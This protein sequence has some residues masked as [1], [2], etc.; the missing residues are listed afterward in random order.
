MPKPKWR[1]YPAGWEFFPSNTLLSR[2]YY[3]VQDVGEEKRVYLRASERYSF[4]QSFKNAKEAKLAAEK[5]WQESV[6]GFFG[7]FTED[8]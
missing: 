4:M 8:E 5:H 7:I 6:L 3:T 1:K 2:Y